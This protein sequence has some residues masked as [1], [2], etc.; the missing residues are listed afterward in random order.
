MSVQYPIELMMTNCRKCISK[1]DIP[2]DTHISCVT[3]S[4]VIRGNERA[5]NKGWFDYPFNFDPIWHLV[6]CPYFISVDVSL[7]KYI[8]SFINKVAVM[9]DIP[10]LQKGV[11]VVQNTNCEQNKE[12]LRKL[13]KIIAETA[14]HFFIVKTIP[15]EEKEEVLAFC[16]YVTN[17]SIFENAELFPEIHK[18]V[19]LVVESLSK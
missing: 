6:R 2:G 13:D 17:N 8:K 12:V 5:I 18:E 3:P 7:N 11:D 14:I 4:H 10:L 16:Q 15:V 19:A 1:R 9:V